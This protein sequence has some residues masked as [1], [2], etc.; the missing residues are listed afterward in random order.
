MRILHLHKVACI[1]LRFQATADAYA[2]I[3]PCIGLLFQYCVLYAGEGLYVAAIA[4]SSIRQHAWAINTHIT[5][6]LHA[7]TFA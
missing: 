2:G 4:Y 3:G 7:N 6:Y 1:A 5:A